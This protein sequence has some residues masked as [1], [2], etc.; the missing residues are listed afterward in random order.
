[1]SLLKVPKNYKRCGIKIKC[2]KCKFQVSDICKLKGTGIG[3]CE[4]Q[5]KH[6]YNLI[7]HIPNTKTGR[8]MKLLNTKDFNTAL[9]ELANF[10]QELKRNGYQKLNDS[11]SELIKTT[12]VTLVAEYLDMISGKNTPKHLIRIRSKGHINES[13]MVFSRFI[14]TLKNNGYNIEILDL[15]N[16]KAKEV[17]LFH[18]YLKDELQL[19]NRA[20]NKHFVIMKTFYNWVI[21]VKGYRVPNL[22]AHAELTFDKNEKTIIAKSE[23]IKLLKKTNYENGWGKQGKENKNFFKPWLVNA[24]RLALET[25]TRTEELVRLKWN[26]IEKVQKGVEVLRIN[27]LKVNRIQSGTDSGKYVRHIPITKG[28]KKLLNDLGLKDN[29]GSDNY[30][31]D[32]EDRAETQ[33]MMTSISR[34]FSHFIKLV[35]NRKIE[36]KDLRKTYITM[37]T[38]QL[39]EKAKLFTGHSNDEVLKSHYLSSAHLA[40]NLNDYEIFK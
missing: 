5:D 18:D 7:V 1:M 8:K 38:I 27:N 34:G 3:T 21:D 16:I 23:F 37:L 14:I 35:T 30:I 12:I 10:K 24:F 32:R 31:L 19:G 9:I 40:G 28:L 33:Y 39:G 15:K 26:D 20:Y 36:F 4:H 6:R 17:E 22:F 29:E 25:G 13:T 2:L 11:N